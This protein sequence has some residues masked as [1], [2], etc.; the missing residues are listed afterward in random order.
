MS[1]AEGFAKAFVPGLQQGANLIL[2]GEMELFRESMK[3]FKN[4]K[5]KYTK[6][7]LE[8]LKIEQQAKALV[9][10]T[11]GIP[12]S[13]V[14]A[15]YNSLRA[16]RSAEAIRRDLVEGGI[17]AARPSSSSPKPAS[18]PTMTPVDTQMSEAGLTDPKVTPASVQG[19][20]EPTK[21]EDG[22]VSFNFTKWMNQRRDDAVGKAANMSPD[23][24]KTIKSG[25]T[26]SVKESEVAIVPRPVKGSGTGESKTLTAGQVAA[27]LSR[28]EIAASTG[29]PKAIAARDA[30]LA[31]PYKA[32]MNALNSV[33]GRPA[34]TTLEQSQANYDRAVK[35]GDQAAIEAAGE[36]LQS[37]MT[38]LQAKDTL[39]NSGNI[40]KAYSVKP[41]GTPEFK[42]VTV[43]PKLGGG[44]VMV[45]AATNQPLDSNVFKPVDKDQQAAATGVQRSMTSQINKFKESNA[46]LASTV[47]LAGDTLALVDSEP[48]ALTWVA[49]QVKKLVGGVREVNTAL[50]V[51]K[52]LLGND[53]NATIRIPT[54]E[55]ALRDRGLLAEGQTLESVAN[56]DP[57]KIANLA[58]A[59]AALDAKLTLLTFRTGAMEGQSGNAMSNKDF[60]RLT[61]I[62][63]STS[64]PEGFKSNLTNYVRGLVY[65]QE[66]LAAQLNSDTVGEAAEFKRTYG[67]RPVESVQGFN[68]LVDSRNDPALKGSYQ[69]IMGSRV[70]ATPPT[71]TQSTQQP[72]T[73]A[74]PPAQ[75]QQPKPP[76]TVPI[77]RGEVPQAAGIPANVKFVEIDAQGRAIYQDENGKKFADRR[78]TYSFQD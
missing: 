71:P 72:R 35:S 42:N 64:G 11:P 18:T 50:G 41:D 24:V 61:T 16:G 31:G 52:E 66:D 21:N 57:S 47:R 25:Y 46:A 19:G 23:Q 40:T 45:D 67:Y 12:A 38:A 65:K 49:D 78:F 60:E 56:Q 2:Q 15:V 13:A 36:E 33:K 32:K 22:S 58:Q 51:A 37:F 20:S 73:Q 43:R 48:R 74:T 27:E 68:T 76:S 26:P 29:D 75:P 6:A 70:P 1:F 59:R 30:Y 14:P 10:E 62:V 63:R 55:N 53:P 8:D 5:N 17:T 54:L 4:E 34:S 7:Q 3:D 39:S 9:K 77:K 44:M 69:R 28:Y